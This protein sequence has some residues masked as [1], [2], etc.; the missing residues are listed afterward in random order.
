MAGIN[1]YGPY[2]QLDKKFVSLEPGDDVL[3]VG[4][5][6]AIALLNEPA[7]AAARAEA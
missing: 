4:M 2:V 5:N 3:T 7:Q 6:R 1:R